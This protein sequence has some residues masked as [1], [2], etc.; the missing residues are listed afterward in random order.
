MKVEILP[1]AALDLTS[2]ERI[3]LR[4]LPYAE[5]LQTEF[6]KIVRSLVYARAGHRCEICYS[7]EFLNVHHRS[8]KNHG[9]E[10]LH[11]NDLLCMCSDCHE[12]FHLKLGLDAGVRA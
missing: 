12:L 7:P 10:D 5:F 9:F 3:W 6:W 4:S 11:L 8:Y 1:R 2:A